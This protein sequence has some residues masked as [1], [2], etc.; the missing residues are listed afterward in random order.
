MIMINLR[1]FLQL[2]IK[3]IYTSSIGGAILIGELLLNDDKS[4]PLEVQY[5]TMSML[6]WCGECARERSGLEYKQLL[7][8]HGFKNIQMKNTGTN[9]MDA[10]I[11]F[12]P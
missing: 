6:L 9:I 10:I 7:E 12:K 2:M 3:N 4:G 1:L 8:K 5:M 11:A